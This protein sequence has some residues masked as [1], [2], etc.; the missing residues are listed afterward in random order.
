MFNKDFYPTLPKTIAD[1]VQG[2]DLNGKNILDPESGKGDIL[3][4]CKDLGAKT[5]GCEIQPELYEASKL[6]G[7]MIGTDFMELTR[8]DVAHMDC[9]IMNPPFSA[10]IRHIK[11]AW[12]IA[13]EG[14]IIRALCN[15]DTLK[16]DRF[17]VKR[18]LTIVE[19]N[20]GIILELGQCFTTAE[21]KTNVNVAMIAITKPEEEKEDW[22]SYFSRENIQEEFASGLM[23][24]NVIDEIV[25]R[26]VGSLK[27]FE[28]VMSANKE[29]EEIMGP[30]NVER[31]NFGCTQ[32]NSQ[33]RVNHLGYEDFKK[34]LQKSAW[35]MVFKKMNMEKY[36]TSKLKETIAKFVE[37]Q[38][39]IPFTVENIYNML[40]FIAS[41]N[42][43]RMDDVLIEVF[44]AFT[45]HHDENRHNVEGWKTNSHYM[46]NKK[47][48][49]PYVVQQRYRGG[50]ELNYSGNANKIDD[51]TKALCFLVGKDYEKIGY[52]SNHISN[53]KIYDPERYRNSDF[54]MRLYKSKYENR[55]KDFS[56]GD[57][58]KK[59]YPTVES[60]IEKSIELDAEKGEASER[61]EFGKWYTWGFF[62]IKAFKKGTMHIKF[63]D[64][65]VCELFNLRVAEAKGFELPDSVLSK[66]TQA[67]RQENPEKPLIKL[68]QHV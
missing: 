59:L 45:K 21:R 37:Q 58:Y 34:A 6:Y 44:D 1:L 2:L 57:K 43:N 5:Y 61:L 60:Y 3:K 12:A 67:K 49:V 27:K 14:C 16:V 30:I 33:G 47:I 20:N 10:D 51:L 62:E 17:A 23:K 42:G 46:I 56:H 63:I 32:S 7:K 15:A 36:M 38:S 8:E 24:A 25:G 26:Y 9:I 13:P 22:D 50:F 29:I 35:K 55:I 52:L 18:L 40:K 64:E 68:I 53:A 54:Y 11:H 31:I 28:S 65:K 19:E 4:Y 66:E 39:E 48:I 41:T